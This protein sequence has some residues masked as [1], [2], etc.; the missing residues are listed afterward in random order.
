[1]SKNYVQVEN[2]PDL[3]RDMETGAVVNRNRHAYEQA[4]KRAAEAQRQRDEIRN[5]TRE[6][7][8]I[9]CEMHEIKNLLK[10][11]IGKE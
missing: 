8:H 10:E 7:N 9:K 4:K 1:M 11:L 2:H 6:I 5:T 3:A